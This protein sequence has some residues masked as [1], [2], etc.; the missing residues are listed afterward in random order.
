MA[1]RCIA[2]DTLTEVVLGKLDHHHLIGKLVIPI[3]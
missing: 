2:R 3:I 1:P